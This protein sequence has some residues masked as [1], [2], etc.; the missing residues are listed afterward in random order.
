MNAV[1]T[2]HGGTGVSCCRG[3]KVGGFL[4][5]PPFIKYWDG[6]RA[7]VLLHWHNEVAACKVPKDKV[8]AGQPALDRA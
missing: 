7:R 5:M 8:P 6:H 2:A 4:G 1:R 3:G